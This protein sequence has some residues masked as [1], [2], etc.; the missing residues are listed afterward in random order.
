MGEQTLVTVLAGAL[1]PPVLAHLVLQAADHRLLRLLGGGCRSCRG[2]V[3]VT[4]GSSA[5]LRPL[6][7]AIEGAALTG[8]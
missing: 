4:G 5:A 2:L 7:G 1:L 8:A 6:V 3:T